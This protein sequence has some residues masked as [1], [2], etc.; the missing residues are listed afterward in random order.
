MTGDRADPRSTD[1][2]NQQFSTQRMNFINCDTAIR[3]IWDWGFVW[4]SLRIEGGNVGIGAFPDVD[5]DGV[6]LGGHIG[7]IS[8]V[9]S[10]IIG[11]KKAIASDEDE[12]E[13]TP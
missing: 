13:Y 4:K 2:G 1:G 9:D 3:L 12:F 8:L 7:S 11:V 10:E 5:E 6:E